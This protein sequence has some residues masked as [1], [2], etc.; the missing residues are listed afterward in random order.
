MMTLRYTSTALGLFVFGLIGLASVGRAAEAADAPQP[1]ISADAG[2]AILQMSKTLS[3]NE[4]SFQAR[5]IRVYQ[6]D[7][8]QPLH[9]STP[10]R[11]LC[12][13]RIDSLCTVPATMGP[14]ICTTTERR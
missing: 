7:Q 8:G 12:I 2:A 5:T 1:G 3:A 10:R 13:D 9:I 6:D 14:P 4:F 11:S